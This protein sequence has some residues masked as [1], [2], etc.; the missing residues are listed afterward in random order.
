M[1]PVSVEESKH[2]NTLFKVTPFYGLSAAVSWHE[3]YGALFANKIRHKC[4]Y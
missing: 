1:S 3:H 2:F 4:D